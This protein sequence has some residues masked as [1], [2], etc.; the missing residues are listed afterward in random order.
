MIPDIFKARIAK[1]LPESIHA[2]NVIPRPLLR[3]VAS[4]AYRCI[5]KRFKSAWI[6]PQVIFDKLYAKSPAAFWLDSAKVCVT[7]MKAINRY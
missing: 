3:E 6:S 1:R 4:H 5:V 7:Q 2:L